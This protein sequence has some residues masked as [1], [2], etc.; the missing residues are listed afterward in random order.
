MIRS[1]APKIQWA[2]RRKPPPPRRRVLPHVL[3][4][5]V[6]IVL[7][8]ALVAIGLLPAF[9][10]V[11]QAIKRIDQHFL[12]NADTSLEIPPFPER[13]TIYASDGKTVLARVASQNRKY[14]KLESVSQIARDAVLAIEDHAFYKHGP[15]N[16]SSILR[17]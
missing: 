8:S 10:G 7:A 12:G 6:V 17:A 11:G 4:M 16:V 2:P 5:P 3:L 13:S 9:S 14:V 1:R 15:I